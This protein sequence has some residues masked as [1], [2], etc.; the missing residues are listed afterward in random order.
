MPDLWSD[1]LACLDLHPV[2]S[3]GTGEE[4]PARRDRVRGPQS[5]ARISPRV[6]RAT[7]RP[8]HPIAALTDPG[9]AVKSQHAVFARGAG[10]TSPF[11]TKPSPSRRSIVRHRSPSLPPGRARGVA[12]TSTICMHAQEGSWSPASVRRR[13]AGPSS[14]PTITARLGHGF[15]GKPARPLTSTPPPTGPPEFELWMRTPAVDQELAPALAAY[16]TDLTLIGT[17]LRPMD[18]VDQR[19][20]RHGVHLRGRRR[21]PSGFTDRSAPTGGCC[22]PAQPSAGAWPRFRPRGDMPC[23]EDGTLVALLRP[24]S[25]AALR[26]REAVDAPKPVIPQPC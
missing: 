25:P 5:T 19:G 12:A 2:P 13:G 26:E 8:V 11:D 9:K 4:T 3:E 14:V 18:G 24:R 23:T 21:T 1:L 16:A 22:S 17:A 7:P 20:Q 15:R 6:R 10:P